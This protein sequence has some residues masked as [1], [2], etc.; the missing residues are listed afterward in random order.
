MEVP[1]KKDY[2][3]KH[4][5]TKIRIVHFPSNP[6]IKLSHIIIPILKEIEAEYTNIE[7]VIKSGI[8]HAE[9][10]EELEQ[11]HIVIDALGLSYG[12]LAI[13]AM[14]RGCVVFVGEMDFMNERIPDFACIG[15][16]SNNLKSK[17]VEL[18]TNK[19]ILLE[20]AK[21]SIAFYEKYHTPKV[22]GNYYKEKL[23]LN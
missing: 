2:L 17:I 22:A 3:L 11:A 15:A 18:I 8:P 7:I 19:D 23:N 9:V 16:T 12:M 20:K 21:E 14:A 4:T 1:I 13:E 5:T 6:I 10:I